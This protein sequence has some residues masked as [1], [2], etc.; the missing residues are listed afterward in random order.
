MK[1]IRCIIGA[2]L[3]TAS[4]AF[5]DWEGNVWVEPEA[6]YEIRVDRTIINASGTNLMAK[7][8]AGQPYIIVTGYAGRMIEDGAW[9]TA[10]LKKIG[11]VRIDGAQILR[12]DWIRGDTLTWAE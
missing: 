5:A 8:S 4:T 11:V 2:L 7:F 9:I 6:R 3:V 12:Y 1:Y 10:A